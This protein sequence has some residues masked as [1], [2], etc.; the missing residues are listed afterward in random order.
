MMHPI[1]HITIDII[2]PTPLVPLNSP[3]SPCSSSVG[4]PDSAAS[5]AEWFG[6]GGGRKPRPQSAVA[7]LGQINGVGI[8]PFNSDHT[9][10]GKTAEAVYRKIEMTLPPPYLGKGVWVGGRASKQSLA[11]CFSND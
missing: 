5:I 4:L 9:R 8:N 10:H 6:K 1:N 2:N 11:L 7:E 3:S